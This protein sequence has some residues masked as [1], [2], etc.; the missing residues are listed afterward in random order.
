MQWAVSEERRGW[1]SKKVD[2]HSAMTD[3]RQRLVRSP[4]QTIP[5]NFEGTNKSSPSGLPPRT[6][7]S[8]TNVTPDKSSPIVTY[9][10]S[11]YCLMSYVP[12][13]RKRLR[14]RLLSQHLFFSFFYCNIFTLV[15]ILCEW[16]YLRLLTQ[17][18]KASSKWNS[19]YHLK[20]NLRV[21]CSYLITNERQLTADNH[22]FS[23][24]S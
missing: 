5:H 12:R 20:Y 19:Q 18:Y 2:A 11:I 24:V 9:R 10:Y 15:S 23:C 6:K 21:M 13:L 7:V 14:K 16:L 4:W 3:H 1:L 17:C 22:L 8:H